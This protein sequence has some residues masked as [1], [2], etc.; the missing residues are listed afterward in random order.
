ME[1]VTEE[2]WKLVVEKKKEGRSNKDV[3]DMVR[4]RFGKDWDSKKIDNVYSYYRNYEES[5]TKPLKMKLKL[6]MKPSKTKS[7]HECSPNGH[8]SGKAYWIQHFLEKDKELYDSLIIIGFQ[9]CID[10]THVVIGELN[11]KVVINDIRETK[12]VKCFRE[13]CTNSKGMVFVYD[14]LS[15]EFQIFLDGVSKNYG[16]CAV[17][18]NLT[19]RFDL[20][21]S[22]RD[23]GFSPILAVVTPHSGRGKPAAESAVEKCEKELGAKI[24]PIYKNGETSSNISIAYI[25]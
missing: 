8:H 9:N 2:Q 24:C 12:E 15:P 7:S 5:K 22:L 14:A 19:G 11:K 3:T 16:R 1:K 13:E 4:S 17:F 6:K 20:I 23:R 10:L 21:K 25:K 18:V